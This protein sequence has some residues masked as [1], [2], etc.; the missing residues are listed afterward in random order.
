MADPTKD[1]ALLRAVLQRVLDSQCSRASTLS[2]NQIEDIRGALE[3]TAPP[4]RRYMVPM[5]AIVVA[6]DE[7]SAEQRALDVFETA[8]PGDD[9]RIY[10]D[11]LDPVE[12]APNAIINGITQFY[13]LQKEAANG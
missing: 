4:V 9:A 11:E 10:V 6:E 13:P 7:R 3:Q 1:V 5:F 2:N 12:L 8:E